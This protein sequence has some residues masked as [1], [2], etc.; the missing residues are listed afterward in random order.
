M[1]V[2]EFTGNHR[3]TLRY[4]QMA[5]NLATTKCRSFFQNQPQSSSSFETTPRR[6]EHALFFDGP[7]AY[8]HHTPLVKP[9]RMFLYQN[10]LGK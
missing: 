1:P 8:P 3:H 7:F 9:G 10:R 2:V 5:Y 4:E 6:G